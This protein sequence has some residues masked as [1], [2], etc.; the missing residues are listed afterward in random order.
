M[1]RGRARMERLN[2]R[3]A[4]G[5]APPSHGLNRGPGSP[6]RSAAGAAPPSHGPSREPD[7]RSP[8]AAAAGSPTGDPIPSRRVA[9]GIRMPRV[10]EGPSGPGRRRH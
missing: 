6:S 7:C 2:R 5:A 3:S 4:A 9:G 8:A 1:L 10:P